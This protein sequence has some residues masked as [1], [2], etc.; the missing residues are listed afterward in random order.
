MAVV[1]DFSYRDK[2][3]W[4]LR[5]KALIR[6]GYRCQRCGAN[7]YGKGKSRVDHIVPVRANLQ[8]AYTLSNLR[9]LCP[10][11]DNKRHWEKGHANSKNRV[12]IGVDGWPVE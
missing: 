4:N 10:S 5:R 12:Q 8:L 6:D 7:I 3:W 11:C 2:R 1:K 9:C